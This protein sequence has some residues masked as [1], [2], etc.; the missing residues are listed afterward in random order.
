VPVTASFGVC[1]VDFGAQPATARAMIVAAD[2]AL[3]RA[4][5]AGRNTVRTASVLEGAGAVA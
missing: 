2:Q 3:Y 5:H 4:K 1:G